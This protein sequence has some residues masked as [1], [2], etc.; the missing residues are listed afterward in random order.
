MGDAMSIDYEITKE[1]SE[2]LVRDALVA[3]ASQQR[4]AL[5]EAWGALETEDVDGAREATRRG[6]RP[7]AQEDGS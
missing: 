7:W 3:Y 2:R 1:E 6:L 5:Q 4:R